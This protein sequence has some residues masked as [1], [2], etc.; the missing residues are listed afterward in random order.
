MIILFY[1]LICSVPTEEDP[2][3]CDT[4]VKFQKKVEDAIQALT[5][6]HILYNVRDDICCPSALLFVVLLSLT[7]FY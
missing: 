6:K 4:L 7:R 2:C 3:E 5:K 1:E